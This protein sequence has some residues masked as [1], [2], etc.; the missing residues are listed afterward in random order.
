M[1]ELQERVLREV[2]ASREETGDEKAEKQWH[3]VA[4]LGFPGTML[5]LAE[6]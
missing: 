2:Q 6:K 3:T 1:T 5:P 4:L